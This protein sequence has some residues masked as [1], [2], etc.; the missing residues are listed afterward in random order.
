[1]SL[2]LG[3]CLTRSVSSFH[4]RIGVKILF[5]E[6]KFTLVS[7]VFFHSFRL[8]LGLCSLREAGESSRFDSSFLGYLL[9][10]VI[11]P[12]YPNIGIV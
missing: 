8:R 7:L 6:L 11:Y 12:A 10:L 2:T 9:R 4:L 3:H 5:F 1:M